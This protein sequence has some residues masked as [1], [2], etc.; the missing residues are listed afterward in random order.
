MST[1]IE[2]CAYRMRSQ[3]ISFEVD[4]TATKSSRM[5]QNEGILPESILNG[6]CP[7]QSKGIE[8]PNGISTPWSTGLAQTPGPSHLPTNN[9]HAYTMKEKGKWHA[10]NTTA[11]M[12][13]RTPRMKR[14]MT[15]RFRLKQTVYMCKI[16][17]QI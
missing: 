9:P 6:Q 17:L 11:E 10:G 16:C 3:K 14:A 2:H 7:I 15:L 4:S 12:Q 1:K 5:A 8:V 13:N